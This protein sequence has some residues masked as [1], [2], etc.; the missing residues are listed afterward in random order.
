M[1]DRAKLQFGYQVELKGNSNINQVALSFKQR[2]DITDVYP[3]SQ[4]LMIVQATNEA[5]AKAKNHP[6]VQSIGRIASPK[7][8]DA[9]I[10]P[11][12]PQFPWNYDNFGPIYIPQKGKTVALNMEV[13]PLYKRL[14]SEYEGHKIVSN[15]NQI[16][17]DDQPVTTYTFEQ[18][19]YW[20]MGDNRNNSIDS[21]GWGFVPFDH[22]VGKPVFIWMSWD[23]IKNPRWER[24]FTTVGGS[25]KPTSYLIP[26]LILL[27]AW[28]GY[29]KW[30]KKKKT[31]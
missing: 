21:R 27:A 3:I 25:G 1:P 7:G 17:I 8:Q 19:Y 29:S 20:M 31:Q 14:I 9:N 11:R 28:F 10:F 4:N 12:A 6:S 24:W 22:V 30:R 23:G 15:G 18:D 26:F 5:I 13:L 16:L 2:Y